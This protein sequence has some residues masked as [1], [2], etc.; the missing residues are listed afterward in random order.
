[1]ALL[2]YLLKWACHHKAWE[3]QKTSKRDVQTNSFLTS[4]GKEQQA[5]DWLGSFASSLPLSMDQACWADCKPYTC[6]SYLRVPESRVRNVTSRPELAPSV[7]L[8]RE[9]G[10][11][12]HRLE[13]GRTP[14][15]SALVRG[16]VWLSGSTVGTNHGK[17]T[18]KHR[19]SVWYWHLQ[20]MS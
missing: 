15:T 13:M 9:E 1:M 18:K 7:T 14:T 11:K 12:N 3:V 16:Q 8:P 4:Q 5:L 6:S 20:N 17:A 10:E 2:A 19:K